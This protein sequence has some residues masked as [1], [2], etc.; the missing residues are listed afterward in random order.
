MLAITKAHL[1]SEEE[2]AGHCK[3]FAEN[4]TGSALE[5]FSSL[6]PSS[7]DNFTQLEE[8]HLR[9]N[10]D[11]DDAL[12]KANAFARAEEEYEIF[13]EKFNTGLLGPRSNFQ[14][15]SLNREPEGENIYDVANNNEQSSRRS[16]HDKHKRN[17]DADED[18]SPPP[19]LKQQIDMI[20]R[21]FKHY[22]GSMKSLDTLPYAPKKTICQRLSELSL[23]GG[24]VEAYAPKRINF[25]S[26]SSEFCRNPVNS[27]KG[28]QRKASSSSNC[29]QTLTGPDTEIAFLES[30]TLNLEKPHDDAL[31]VQLDIAGFELS[32]IMI[33]T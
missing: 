13:P 6:E 17:R 11:L 26:G 8:L 30:E 15:Q 24:G 19:A 12:H 1:T 29:P 16:T 4:L 25:I 7:I 10:S 32:R 21:E 5:W 20:F 33:D 27:I 22:S 14:D 3:F 2:E 23:C 9:H 28:F 18:D 31:V